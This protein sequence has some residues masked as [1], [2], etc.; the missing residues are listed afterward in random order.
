MAL[1]MSSCVV[2]ETTPEIRGKVI[3]KG[4]KKPIQGALVVAVH[5]NMTDVYK[6]THSQDDGAF[7]VP[8][9][10]KAFFLIGASVSGADVI[11]HAPKFKTLCKPAVYERS[12]DD[13]NIVDLG[14]FMLT[15][16]R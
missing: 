14:T 9:T 16:N 13:L 5:P 11:I 10:S 15:P 6:V 12:R 2:V 4:S 7:R 8:S 1:F 3:A